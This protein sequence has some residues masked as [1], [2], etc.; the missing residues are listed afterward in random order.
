MSPERRY[1][2]RSALGSDSGW[3][4]HSRRYAD[5]DAIARLSRVELSELPIEVDTWTRFSGHFVHAAGA[6]TLRSMLLLQ[7][8]ASILAHACNVGLEQM[9]QRKPALPDRIDRRESVI[10]FVY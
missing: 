8:Y 4:E 7:L 9:A 3:V 2:V 5:P 10:M 1:P 6:D